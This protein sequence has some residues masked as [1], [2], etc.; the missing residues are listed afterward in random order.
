MKRPRVRISTLMLLVVIVALAVALT[1][2]RRRTARLEA[3]LAQE[4]LRQMRSP[5]WTMWYDAAISLRG[6]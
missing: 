3:R 6:S 2:E 4:A 5:E 1:V